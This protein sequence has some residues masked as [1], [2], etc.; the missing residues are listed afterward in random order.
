MCSCRIG[1]SFVTGNELPESRLCWMSGV[2]RECVLEWL[3]EL[4]EKDDPDS[5]E[6][7]PPATVSWCSSILKDGIG[8]CCATLDT[9]FWRR[10]LLERSGRFE[11]NCSAASVGGIGGSALFCGTEAVSAMMWRLRDLP[12]SYPMRM[13]N[14]EISRVFALGKQR[15]VKKGPRGGATVSLCDGDAY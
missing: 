6:S 3:A 1:M 14:R 7:R 11:S 10:E 15:S 8:G 4:G 13:L 2:S 12:L 5:L 9:G